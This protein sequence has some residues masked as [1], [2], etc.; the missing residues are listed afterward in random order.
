MLAEKIR[1]GLIFI[2]GEL[3]WVEIST[4]WNRGYGI[5]LS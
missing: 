2:K 4:A 5:V 3:R 1:K